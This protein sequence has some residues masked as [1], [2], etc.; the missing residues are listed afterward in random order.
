MTMAMHQALST[1]A[2]R[3]PRVVREHEVLRVAG[4]MRKDEPAEAAKTAIEE[5]LKW[6]QRRCG[7]RLPAEAWDHDSFEYLSGGR[8]SSCVRLKSADSDLWAIRADDPDKSVPERVWT[9]EIVIGLLPDQPAKFSARLLVST[10]ENE[11]AIEPHTPG[12]VQQVVESCRL[13][14]GKYPLSIDPMIVETSDD[15]NELINHLIDPL[16]ELP[17]FVVTLP[18]GVQDEHPSLNIGSLC[19]AMLGIAHV[20]VVKPA[21]TWSLSD[22]FGRF[23]SVF[24]GAARVYMPGFN[25]TADPYSHRL[26]LAD[27]ISNPAGA[28]RCERWIRQLAAEQ[29]VRGT[30]LGGDVLAF[31]TIR[32]ASLELRQKT[33]EDEG[34]SDADLL[35]AAKQRISALEK[36]IEQHISAE[37]YYLGEYEKER[38]RAELAEGQARAAAFRIQQLTQLLKAKGDDPDRDIA[39]PQT[40][41]ELGDWCDEHL[42]GR[43]VLTAAAR[44]GTK[45]PHFRDVEMVARSLLWLS[46]DCRE[47]RIEGGDGTLREF[48]LEEGV[49]NSPCGSDTYDFD[50]NGRTLSADWHI[51]NGGNTRDPSRCLR[52]YYCFDEQT[53]QIIVSDLPAHR[54]TAA[55]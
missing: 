13:A 28:R 9:T 31:S 50:W 36:D 32:N 6:A 54:R 8:N 14:R 25:E 1:L 5:V 37:D 46:N 40:W 47:R 23:R 2:Q 16:R 10:P 39:L 7:G 18:P 49:R 52:I 3:M 4:W 27:Q 41:E 51:K 44:R 20:A 45:N 33:L 11:L 24:G 15:A 17:T 22:R 29:S 19:R 12:F 26:V 53:Q 34:A 42:S 21:M 43:L 55:S 30:K 35:N 38:E 48:V